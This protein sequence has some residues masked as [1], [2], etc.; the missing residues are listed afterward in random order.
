MTI[1]MDYQGMENDVPHHFQ[2]VHLGKGKKGRKRQKQLSKGFSIV[3]AYKIK[4]KYPFLT[5]LEL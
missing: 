1:T 4:E 2:M 5:E 3:G